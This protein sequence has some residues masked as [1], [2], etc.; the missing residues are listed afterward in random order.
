MD[1]NRVVN[2]LSALGH[3]TRLALYRMLVERGPDGLS[4]GVIAERL[5]VPP[6]SLSFH[7]QHL[8]RAGLITQRRLHR[9]LIYAADFTAMNDLLGYLTENCCGRGIAAPACAPLCNP[10][11]PAVAPSKRN[12][13]SA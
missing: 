4:A 5:D 9:Q 6:S 3:E 12:R 11:I 1:S 7:L 8:N 2:S 13:R 10:A